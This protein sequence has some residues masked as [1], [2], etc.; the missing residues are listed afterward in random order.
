MSQAI[1]CSQHQP[2]DQRLASWLLLRSENLACNE[3]TITQQAIADMLGVRRE[4]ISAAIRQLQGAGLVSTRRGHI[5]IIDIA[6]L[7]NAACEC[8]KDITAVY[9]N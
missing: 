4:D 8:L 1:S 7:K 5:T 6:G 3:L 2:I 9:S